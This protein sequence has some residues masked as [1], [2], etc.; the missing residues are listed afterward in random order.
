M[1]G[2]IIDSAG[3]K[4]TIIFNAVLFVIGALMLAGASSLAVLLLG[5]YVWGGPPEVFQVQ[6][7]W[8]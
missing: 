5:R 1:A 4:F 3:R 8:N 2:I 7:E 6:S